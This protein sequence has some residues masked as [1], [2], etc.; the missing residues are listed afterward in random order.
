MRHRAVIA[1]FTG[2]FVLALLA[3]ASDYTALD[4]YVATPDASF[5][6]SLARTVNYPGMA[7]YQLEMVSQTWLTTAE[8]DRPEWH[9]WVTIY[10]P[11]Q[12]TTNTV[13][14]IINGGSNSSAPSA[15][16]LM[17]VLLAASAGAVL[18]DLGQVPNQPLAFAGEA[19]APIGGCDHRLHLGP[20]PADRRGALA[21]APPDD[22]GSRARHGCGDGVPG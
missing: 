13:L 20:F 4:R 2:V 3:R 7:A 17:M 14:L 10:K 18:V 12:V 16:D 15:P 11:D 1:G 21:G 5:R 6:Y 8:V 19:K 9:H 22:K